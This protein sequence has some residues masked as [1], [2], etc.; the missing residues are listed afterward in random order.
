MRN[1]TVSG[2]V[3]LVPIVAFLAFVWWIASSIGADFQTT[4][5]A[6]VR[7][8]VA[9]AVAGGIWWF[10]RLAIPL[11]TVGLA[12]V[13]WPIWWSVIESIALSGENATALVFVSAT[14]PW[15]NTG[16]FKWSVEATLIGL[17]VYAWSRITNN[18]Y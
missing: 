1:E 12:T 6:V 4:L 9:L 17:F 18:E 7:S 10:L 15:W 14:T 2:A 3:L 13:L 5:G 8:L 11:L 16:W